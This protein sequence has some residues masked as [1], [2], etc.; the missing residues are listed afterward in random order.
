MLID[1]V[2]KL[3]SRI[4]VQLVTLIL[5]GNICGCT[6]YTLRVYHASIQL[7]VLT[8]MKTIA[9]PTLQSISQTGMANRGQ[10]WSATCCC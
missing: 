5:S 9:T 1:S 8:K 4:Q 10:I 6:R 7:A 3:F 2:C